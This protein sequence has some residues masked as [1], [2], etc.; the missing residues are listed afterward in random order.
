MLNRDDLLASRSQPLK[1]EK[2]LLEGRHHTSA[3]AGEPCGLDVRPFLLFAPH[4]R[5]VLDATVHLR[6]HF[7]GRSMC[8]RELVREHLFQAVPGADGFGG[9]KRGL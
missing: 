1:G 8:C 6:R 9:I 4:M 5:K 7:H 3:R 2:P